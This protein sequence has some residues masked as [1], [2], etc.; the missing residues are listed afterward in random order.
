MV[1]SKK[2][3]S[4][5]NGMSAETLSLITGTLLS[6][7]F[8]YVPGIHNWY[9]NFEPII[10]RLIMLGLLLLVSVSIYGFSCLGWAADWGISITCS[11]TGLQTLIKQTVLAIIANQ[12]IYSLSPKGR[13]SNIH[14]EN[15]SADPDFV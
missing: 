13:N 5:G 10:K 15:V 7:F 3:F 2:Y 1:A 12:S 11:K 4:G 9:T 6:L 14:E 8:S